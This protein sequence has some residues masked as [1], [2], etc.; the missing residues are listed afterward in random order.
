[1]EFAPYRRYSP[2][3]RA[4]DSQKKPAT[5][6]TSNNNNNNNNNNNINDSNYYNEW[7][8]KDKG[9]TDNKPQ[10]GPQGSHQ[11]GGGKGGKH[12]PLKKAPEADESERWVMVV[13]PP[14]PAALKKEEKKKGEKK[15]SHKPLAED[16]VAVVP[17]WPQ[18]VIACSSDEDLSDF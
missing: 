11:C 3:S 8:P 18:R 2:E 6:T 9:R 4:G 10:Q 14:P 17:T 16:W 1:M 13:V 15:D 5:T 12:T 7:K